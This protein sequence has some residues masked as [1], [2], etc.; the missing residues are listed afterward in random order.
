[1]RSIALVDCDNF[2]ASC[3]RVF[4]PELRGRPLVVLSNNDGCVIA[5]SA[6]AKRLGIGM[7]VPA[8]ECEALFRRYGVKVF[9]SNLALY[10]DMSHRVMSV[11][12]E[13]TSHVEI[14]SIDEAF[15]AL[16]G[17]EGRESEL[18]RLR[19]RIYQW[20]GIPVS[21]GVGTTKTLAKIATRVAKVRRSHVFNLSS[22]ESVDRALDWVEVGDVWGIGRAG[23]EKL[24]KRGIRTALDLKKADDKWV[25]KQLSVTGLRTVHELR[26]TPCL[27][28][29]EVRPTRKSVV[30]S[31]SFGRRMAGF[32]PLKEAVATFVSRAGEKLRAE[33]LVATYL[34]VFIQT[35]RF[36]QKDRFYAGHQT[37][38]FLVPTSDSRELIS[39]SD[40][41]LCSIFRSG[42]RYA[43][44]G[45]YLQGLL[46][47]SRVQYNLFQP[48]KSV[49]G[50]L[51][52]RGIDEVNDRFGAETV[53][54]AATGV[55]RSWKVKSE[56]RSRSFTTNWKE[57]LVVNS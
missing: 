29:E 1:M 35:S 45:V 55:H 53:R 17:Y 56:K 20:T 7:G 18:L 42:F 19:N 38:E 57:V 39:A 8:F 34:T 49:R 28:L 26:G 24:H 23:R 44:A 21:I 16:D 41:I 27:A 48:K 30:C 11:L 6:E 50:A 14:Y 31:R 2:F 37:Y 40:Q 22:Y 12:K 43:K 47:D 13:F 52:M 46:P 4:C 10:G 54:F 33:N 36:S 5:R 25:L 32:Q 51:L 15:L 9:S 3:E